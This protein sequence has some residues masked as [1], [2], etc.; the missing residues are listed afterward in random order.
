MEL[1]GG[2]LVGQL[3]DVT[4]LSAE[5]QSDGALLIAPGSVYGPGGRADYEPR[6]GYPDRWGWSGDGP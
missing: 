6:P 1:V 2:P 4:G 5:E 3:L